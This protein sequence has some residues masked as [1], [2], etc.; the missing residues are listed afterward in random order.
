M[1]RII[2]LTKDST[3]DCDI[4]SGFSK[5]PF[6]I[7]QDN[8]IYYET[9]FH[10]SDDKKTKNKILYN[11]DKNEFNIEQNFFLTLFPNFEIELGECL[12]CEL[13]IDENNT[14]IIVLERKNG[15]D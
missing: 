9:N 14:N 3:K 6:P 4:I 2:Y 1:K 8:N 10:Y 15:K 12:K 5:K 7:K 13:E 11:L